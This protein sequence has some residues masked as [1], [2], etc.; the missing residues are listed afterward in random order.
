VFC[1]LL[2]GSLVY[3]VCVRGL[4]MLFPQVPVGLLNDKP[5]HSPK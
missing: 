2:V 4:I 5:D 1:V 3:A